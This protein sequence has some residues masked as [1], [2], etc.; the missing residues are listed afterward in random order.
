[1]AN[2]TTRNTVIFKMVKLVSDARFF[3][4]NTEANR[5]AATYITFVHGTKDGLDVF[6]DARLVRGA[7]FWANLKKGDLCVV[8]GEY[9]LVEDKNGDVR[10]KLW[11]ANVSTAV[12]LKSRAAEAGSAS[13]AASESAPATTTAFD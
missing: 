8:E 5:P 9:T 6:V 13:A 10:G 1:M 3:E 11:D 12:D 2:F 7:R 4:E